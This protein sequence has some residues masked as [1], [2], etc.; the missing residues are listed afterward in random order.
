MPASLVDRVRVNDNNREPRQPLVLLVDTSGSMLGDMPDVAAGLASLRA[1]LARD[2]V[3]RNRVE[4]ALVTFGGA[5]TVHGEFGEAAVFEPPALA[6]SGDTP[7]AAAV[8]QALD[9]LDA[10]KRAYKESGLDYY[11]PL[12]FL[13]TDGEPTDTGRWPEAVRRVREAERDRKIVLLAVGTKTA[14][15][16]RLKELSPD[17]APLRLREAQ[18]ETMFQWLSRSLQA[19][20]RSRPG[21]EVPME[22]PTGP[23]GWG[24]L[25]S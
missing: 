9:L 12:V 15:F 24:T 14:N 1:A 7:M 23:R 11:R 20:S 13:L 8:E 5:V 22:D 3:A 10:K 6:A 2:T 18:W 19:R 17:R 25:P 16:N 4:L 21:D